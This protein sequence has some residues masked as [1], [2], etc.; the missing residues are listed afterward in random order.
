MSTI[1]F[2]AYQNS[3]AAAGRRTV[4]TP[5]TPAQQAQGRL[6]YIDNLRWVMILLVVSMHVAVTYSHIGSW[7]YM[8]NTPV[9][10]AETAIFGTYQVWLQSFFMGFLFFIAG[11]FVPRAYDTKGLL[12][13][14]RDRAYRLG[15]PLLLYMFVLQPVAV[16][17]IFLLDKPG[18][19]PGFAELFIHNISSGR[20]LGGTGP[21]WFCEALLLFNAAYA[22]YRKL[23]IH[24]DTSRF[25]A[26]KFYRKP[27]ILVFILA[28]ALC[29]F[30]VRIPWP[31]GTAWYNLQFCYFSQYVFFFAAGILAW[32]GNWLSRLPYHTGIFWGKVALLAGMALWV[33]NIVAGG[34]LTGNLQPY[35][36]G[37]HWQSLVECCREQLVGVGTS[38]FLV[39]WFRDRFNRQGRLA[40]FFSAHAFAVY[41]FHA[42][43]TI[44][45]SKVLVPLHWPLLLKFVLLTVLGILATYALSALLLRR[46]PLLKKIL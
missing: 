28:I 12:R 40:G 5:S 33:I 25:A 17:C 43:V 14:L 42:P 2:P 36:G 3:T 18:T 46:I 8:E 13:F 6:L 10:T 38:L 39:T 45:L 22:L 19:A 34:A 26:G 44:A 23:G 37:V 32:R 27:F 9:S 15:L 24:I 21:L 31:N 4:V 7:Y 30:L 16:Y 29:S 11:Y 41:V 1:S 35:Q 20:W